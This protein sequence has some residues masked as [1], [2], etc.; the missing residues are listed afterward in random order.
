VTPDRGE[1]G[2]GAGAGGAHGGNA[3]GGNGHSE[4]D[5]EVGLGPTHSRQPL[6][7]ALPTAAVNPYTLRSGRSANPSARAD[8]TSP[9]FSNR[10]NA[11][12]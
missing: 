1:G 12:T 6:R 4:G 9:A 8:A 7:H 5:G 11:S 10:V 3:G 2:D